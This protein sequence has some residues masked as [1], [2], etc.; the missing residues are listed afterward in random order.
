MTTITVPDR[1]A[2]RLAASATRFDR[3]LLRA[4]STLDAH[5]VARLERRAGAEERRALAVQAAS[6]D[7][8]R[9]ASARAAIGILPR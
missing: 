5:V 2:Q 7:A 1:S 6:D 4:A 3:A 8:R 9:E